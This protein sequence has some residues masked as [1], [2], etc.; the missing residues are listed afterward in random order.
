MMQ[1]AVFVVALL[2]ISL[3][4]GAVP[5]DDNGG[6][7]STKYVTLASL[8]G[9]RQ[10]TSQDY[11]DGL[12]SYDD[13][14][15]TKCDDFSSLGGDFVLRITMGSF[16]DYII[17]SSGSLTVCDVLTSK[18][19]S[20]NYRYAVNDPLDELWDGYSIPVGLPSHWESAL[21]GAPMDFLATQTGTS[22][23]LRRTIAFWGSDDSHATRAVHKG[24]CCSSMAH[25]PPS[26]AHLLPA[27]HQPL[28]IEVAEVDAVALHLTWVTKPVAVVLCAPVIVVVKVQ[29]FRGE[30]YAKPLSFMINLNNMQTVTTAPSQNGTLTFEYNLCG[31]EFEALMEGD[32]FT[33]KVST[34]APGL[35]TEAS[36]ITVTAPVLRAFE[37]TA[38]DLTAC[39]M[40]S[41]V[42]EMLHFGA[43][44]FALAP[45]SRSAAFHGDWFVTNGTAGEAYLRPVNGYPAIAQS[46]G[47]GGPVTQQWTV[48]SRKDADAPGVFSGRYALGEGSDA[49]SNG[50]LQ[51]Y[52]FTLYNAA[53]QVVLIQ[54]DATEAFALV[55][56][57]TEVFPQA[58]STT[59]S[60]TGGVTSRG[61]SFFY[62]LSRG[63]HQAIVKVFSS[64]A[65]HDNTVFASLRVRVL[66]TGVAYVL[67]PRIGVPGA[68]NDT[69]RDNVVYYIGTNKGKTSSDMLY[70][71]TIDEDLILVGSANPMQGLPVVPGAASGS[72]NDQTW[73]AFMF[74]GGNITVDGSAVPVDRPFAVKYVALTLCN[75]Y[76]TEYEVN[77]T[78]MVEGHTVFYVDGVQKYAAAVGTEEEA[79]VA[80]KLTPGWHQLLVRL[81]TPR[82][83]RWTFRFYAHTDNHVVTF[84]LMDRNAV[85]PYGVRP[86]F[87]S[88]PVMAMLELTASAATGTEGEMAAM[89]PFNATSN[90]ESI[91]SFI[92]FGLGL[93]E[94]DRHHSFFAYGNEV[95]TPAA[96]VGVSDTRKSQAPQ[97]SYHW[98]P[99][100][101]LQG[102]VWGRVDEDLVTG[103]YYRVWALSL[104]AAKRGIVHLNAEFVGGLAVWVNGKLVN[105]YE[106]SETSP[107]NAD[108]RF[109][110]NEW[111]NQVVLKLQAP[112][113][114][115]LTPDELLSED[116]AAS[117][118]PK[119]DSLTHA[120][121]S[122]MQSHPV[123]TL[124]T[125]IDLSGVPAIPPK[126]TAASKQVCSKFGMVP[127]S[128]ASLAKQGA[129]APKGCCVTVHTPSLSLYFTSNYDSIPL[130]S[131]GYSYH[132]LFAI[133]P[134][135]ITTDRAYLSEQRV[136]I[137]GG[138][139]TS[140]RFRLQ[141]SPKWMEYT[142]PFVITSSTLVEAQ[143]YIG[144]RVSDITHT[145]VT[146]PSVVTFV[147]DECLFGQPCPIMFTGA[148]VAS[149]VSLVSTDLHEAEMTNLMKWDNALSEPIS[150]SFSG[151]VPMD[152]D[153]LVANA[154][155]VAP[156]SSSGSAPTTKFAVVVYKGVSGTVEGHVTM[157]RG[158]SV[159]PDTLVAGR[160]ALLK[161]D[162]VLMEGDM[163]LFPQLLTTPNAIADGSSSDCA[164]DT[165]VAALR[166]FGGSDGAWVSRSRLFSAN[167]TSATT[168]GELTCMCVC[169]WCAPRH[170]S[171]VPP[172]TTFVLNPG[173]VAA[174]PVMIRVAAGHNGGSDE[175]AP[176]PATSP[177][178]AAEEGHSG[179]ITALVVLAVL[180]VAGT[181]ALA[182]Y[183]YWRVQWKNRIQNKLEDADHCPYS[184]D[185]ML[186]YRKTDV[187]GHGN[188][189]H[190]NEPWAKS[191]Y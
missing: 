153:S 32:D 5:S 108:I 24:G 110:A 77:W 54:V 28:T 109:T 154:R 31:S 76:A 104:Y 139:G 40:E 143:A 190:A 113:T 86:V 150:A 179:A 51:F 35:V 62:F 26:M 98:V 38:G 78:F 15:I 16:T 128:C 60:T 181:V 7:R 12:T 133:S 11:R 34:T 71:Q 172:G 13:D 30:T 134:P 170:D 120:N 50:A 149:E 65:A 17:P 2:V 19:S 116:N 178:P 47:L 118:R 124:H 59:E 63:Y 29:N 152:A 189:C 96:G 97:L 115:R 129:G 99:T 156:V 145:E 141:A 69:Y 84:P 122:S 138:N 125:H 43:S 94:G 52:A 159:T 151:V 111:W 89:L 185:G 157:R 146:V 180:F 53:D 18:A 56:N 177:M 41:G 173:R 101:S 162:A 175:T 174:L 67:T 155:V 106:A 87:D 72:V 186:G 127:P 90:V 137:S 160:E 126:S 188:L 45:V 82:N 171:G 57:Q 6:V 169:L 182:A 66:T 140:L 23:A 148:T 93:A 39:T 112:S 119:V 80:V 22:P 14:Q 114:L 55:I 100:T 9:G 184:H 121:S 44:D 161:A 144:S 132:E 46:H 8:S 95:I 163:V 75:L 49:A 135:R 68:G 20:G 81:A 117:A 42:A 21:G 36:T 183:C 165:C 74:E 4:V 164:T 130:S 176:T 92:A 107:Q 91:S 191:D 85:L 27:W 10:V 102:G 70:A 167:L 58:G 187:E 88:T 166:T 61:S 33:L 25:R 123:G 3:A 168:G 147:R 158:L 79:S 37:T 48:V 105:N 136:T 83:T 64:Q 103:A 73:D 1:C 142:E 131:L